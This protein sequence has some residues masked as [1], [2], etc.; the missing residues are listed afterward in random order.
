MSVVFWPRLNIEHTRH[1]LI[2]L[3][4]LFNI[5]TATS[6]LWSLA[7]RT[8]EGNFAIIISKLPTTVAEID[9]QITDNLGLRSFGSLIWLMN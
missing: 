8:P 5:M 2:R 1:E 9:N 4:N 7:A 6:L 3:I